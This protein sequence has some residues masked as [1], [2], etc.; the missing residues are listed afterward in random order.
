MAI[1]SGIPVPAVYILDEE[2]SLNAFAAGLNTADAAVTVTR[3]TLDKL[4]RDELQGVIAHEF[5]H[6]LNGDMRLNV[7]ITAIVFGILVVGLLG[8]GVLRGL[9]YGRV[10]GGRPQQ[11]RRRRAHRRHRPGP[12]SHRLCGVFFRPHDP[13][14]RL[15][16]ARILRRRLGRPVHA[17]SRRHRRSAEK[18][19][20]LRAR[21]HHH[22]QPRRRDRAFL[23]CA[24][25]F[26]AA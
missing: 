17:Q 21:W 25:V 6:I 19:R 22:S 18:N 8:Q 13:G 20:R 9:M 26:A 3:G 16:P 5:S 14:R 4:T 23:L 12:V 1:A 7:H 10:R 2:P 11:R 24:G 15:A